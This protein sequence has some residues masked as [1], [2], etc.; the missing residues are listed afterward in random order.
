MT[1][2]PAGPKAQMIAL[3]VAEQQILRLT[4]CPSTEILE[5]RAKVHGS[6]EVMAFNMATFSDEVFEVMS[7]DHSRDCWGVDH[8]VGYIF[9]ERRSTYKES[10]EP[11]LVPVVFVDNETEASPLSLR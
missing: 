11:A 10:Y 3:R 1:I 4:E 7:L 5:E 8:L 9:A 6:I 2:T